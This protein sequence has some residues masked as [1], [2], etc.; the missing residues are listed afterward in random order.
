LNKLPI[1]LLL[2]HTLYTFGCTQKAM[3]DQQVAMLVGGRLV[4][5][6]VDGGRITAA[7]SAQA[8]R[9]SKNKPKLFP[10]TPNGKYEIATAMNDSGRPFN[11]GCNFFIINPNEELE[12]SVIKASEIDTIIF[13]VKHW[14][15]HLDFGGWLPNSQ[16]FIALTHDANSSHEWYFRC[17]IDMAKRKVSRFNGWASKSMKTAIV[18]DVEGMVVEDH[19]N[20]DA[21][22]NFIGFRSRLNYYA[23]H[24]PADIS[25]YHFASAPKKMLMFQRRPFQLAPD[26]SE[27]QF[28]SSGEWAICRALS[29]DDSHLYLISI[30]AG[31]VRQLNGS[32]SRF[33]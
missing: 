20:R 32:E 2:L 28:S 30:A 3:A 1:L 5:Q 22:H 33:L 6:P 13:G 25:N 15:Y 24:I 7:T 10:D 11:T 8:S 4:V 12:P 29:V 21:Q 18:P 23:A 16:G 27:V 17:V 26:Q 9:W 14:Q 19:R 31:T